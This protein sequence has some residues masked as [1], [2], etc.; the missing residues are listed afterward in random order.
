MARC[1]M[2]DEGKALSPPLN[3]E[4]GAFQVAS[5]LNKPFASARTWRGIACLFLSWS[6]YC[7]SQMR[8]SLSSPFINFLD[9]RSTLYQLDTHPREMR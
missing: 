6:N 7:L 8:C 9:D 5:L 4:D 2:Q 1:A 3:S